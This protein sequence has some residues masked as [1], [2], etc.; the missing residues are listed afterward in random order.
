MTDPRV[1]AIR[2]TNGTH[3]FRKLGNTTLMYDMNLNHEVPDLRRSCESPCGRKPIL[4]LLPLVSSPGRSV[5]GVR[6]RTPL[7]SIFIVIYIIMITGSPTYVF[8]LTFF[9]EALHVALKSP[10]WFYVS[11]NQVCLELE[12]CEWVNHHIKIFTLEQSGFGLG[13]DAHCT[14][15]P[16]PKELFCTSVMLS[17]SCFKTA[18]KKPL[19]I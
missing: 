3:S 10:C 8:L 2:C 7:D 19:A 5:P 12:A 4:P 17:P 14:Y 16:P 15:P 13:L 6:A 1:L 11:S 18:L 9:I